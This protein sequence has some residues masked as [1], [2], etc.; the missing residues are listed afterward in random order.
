M[1][2]WYRAAPVKGI[3]LLV[4]HAL[5]V[6][7]TVSLIWMAAYP[8]LA[9]DIVSGKKAAAYDRSEGFGQQVYWDAQDILRAISD[10]DDLETDGKLDENKLVDIE[11]IC[12]NGRINRGEQLRARLHGERSAGLGKEAGER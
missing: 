5:V 6:L 2:K 4:Q 7:V 10:K 1:N 12:A 8:G 3:L 11:E 9:G